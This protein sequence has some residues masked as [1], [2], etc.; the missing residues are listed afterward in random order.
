M[1]A[2]ARIEGRIAFLRTE[3]QIT[4]AQTGAWNAF[5]D[6]LRA[7]AR[8]MEAMRDRMMGGQMPGRMQAGQMQPGQ[9]QPGQ[10]QPGQMPGGPAAGRMMPG[11]GMRAM[12]G[13]ALSFPDHADRRVQVLTARLDAARAIATA[14][15]ALYAVLTDAQKA[16][17]DE[18]LAV[19]MR[20]M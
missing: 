9:M 5:A 13:A 16:T 1:M 14:G 10:M 4:E 2:P 12:P 18:L 8:G 11:G 15:R 3:L 7:E 19:P 6:V 17:A 20:G